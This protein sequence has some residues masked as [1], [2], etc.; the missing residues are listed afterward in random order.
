MITRR[1]DE[2]DDAFAARKISRRARLLRKRDAER[3]ERAEREA[4][5]QAAVDAENAERERARIARK[6]SRTQRDNLFN[7]QFGPLPVRPTPD[8]SMTTPGVPIPARSDRGRPPR[9]TWHETYFEGLRRG[10]TKEVAAAYA[11]VSRSSVWQAAKRDPDFAEKQE[12]AT[13]IGTA[14]LMDVARARITDKYNPGDRI[15]THLLSHRG[16]NARQIIEHQGADGGPIQ[17]ESMSGGASAALPLHRLPLELRRQIMVELDR[18][19]AEDERAALVD[20]E[21]S[22]K[23]IEESSHTSRESSN[24]DGDDDVDVDADVIDV[25]ATDV[26]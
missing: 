13:G 11:G 24:G 8:P 26:M 4:A 7:I 12:I 22:R 25:E 2:S 5:L 10:Y 6:A 9:H 17:T 3:A 16:I 15:L 14:W 21:S 18:I 20:A 19:K 23:Q 1:P